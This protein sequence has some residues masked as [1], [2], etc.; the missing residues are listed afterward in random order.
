MNELI[1]SIDDL[2][3]NI[4]VIKSKEKEDYKIIAVVKGNAYG[5]GL[6]EYV[7]ILKDMDIDFFAVATYKEALE[8]R[9]YFKDK[10]LL[11][12]PYFDEEIL[13]DLIDKDVV[14]TIDSIKQNLLID[15]I[16]K[17]KN[18]KVISH[19]KVDTGLNRYGFKYSDYESIISAINNTE[20][21]IYEGIFS[22]FSNSLRENNS[23]SEL[24]YKR[25][26]DVIDKLK[27][28]NI[29]FDLKHIC[30]S[31]GYFKYPNM[32]LNASRIG[33]A[34]IG[35]AV[36]IKTDLKQVGTF[37]TKVTKVLDI[38]QGETVGYA[39]SFIAPKNMTL[40]ILPCGYFDGIGKTLVDQRFI[41]KSKV[42]RLLIDIKKIF[43]QDYYMINDFKVVGQIG[44]HDVVLDIENKDIKINDDIYFDVKPTLIDSSVKRV[45]KETNKTVIE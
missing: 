41:F 24:Q 11:L 27:E 40:A 16:A 1:I 14:L 4:N 23:F 18:K 12:T 2:V 15:K 43:K 45:Y 3:H 42:K 39:N 22:H 10:L 33:S 30:N 9:N 32:H 8:F 34:F 25:F 13:K 26:T 35:R 36:G 19:I 21:I 44:M 7:E 38:K 6:K 29:E 17:E 5:C 28:K 20:N 37:H 31:S